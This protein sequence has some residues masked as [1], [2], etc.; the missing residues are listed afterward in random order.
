M[1]LKYT[2]VESDANWGKNVSLLLGQTDI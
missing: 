2:Y 1:R